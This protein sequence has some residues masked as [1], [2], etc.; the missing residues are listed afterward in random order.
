M[1]VEHISDR[2]AAYGVPGVR[3]DGNDPD[4]SFRVLEEAVERARSG[5]GPSLIECVTYRFRGHSHGDSMTYMPAEER[6]E[7]EAN[8]P[9]PAYG[10]RLLAAGVLS[11]KELGDIEAASYGIG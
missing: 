7:A 6:R 3:V 8:D 4:A 9:V 5:G 11:E 2:A 10:R 1:K